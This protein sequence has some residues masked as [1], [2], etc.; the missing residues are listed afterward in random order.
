MSQRSTSLLETGLDRVRAT[1]TTAT[2]ELRRVQKRVDVQR[3]TLEKRV[4]SRRKALEKRAAT[5]L[6][7]VLG[8]VRGSS[9]ARTADALRLGATRQI[10][11]GLETVLGALQIPTRSELERI[12]RKL[13]QISRKLKDLEKGSAAAA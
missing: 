3:R 2:K 11:A 7:R 4:A 6:D 9:L 13:A 8:Q 1:V 10:E 12:D 5:E